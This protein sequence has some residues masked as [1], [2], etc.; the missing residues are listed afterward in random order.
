MA[1]RG[2]LTWLRNSRGASAVEFAIVA[3][4]F[5]IMMFG[6]IEFGRAFWI[7]STLQ[8]AV[9]EAGRYNMVYTSKTTAEIQ[10]YAEGKLPA[11][12][13]G[14]TVTATEE[15]TGVDEFMS[16]TA[17]FQFNS[18]V[19][20]LQIPTITLQAKARVPIDLN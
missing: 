7:K 8:F 14:A 4:I 12:L 6:I 9:E 13:S 16:I 3:P 10:A 11:S 15:T 1:R 2:I 17:S 20:L 5:L 18:L 19:P